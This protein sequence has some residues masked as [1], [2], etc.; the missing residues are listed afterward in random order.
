MQLIQGSKFAE[1]FM[2]FVPD[3]Y[4]GEH[5]KNTFDVKILKDWDT[6]FIKTDFLFKFFDTIADCNKGSSM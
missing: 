2:S 3:Y 1:H 5:Y 6:V 4:K